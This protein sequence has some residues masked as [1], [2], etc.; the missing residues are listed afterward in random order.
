MIRQK[1]DRS[2]MELVQNAKRY[3]SARRYKEEMK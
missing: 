3:R 2:D 1:G